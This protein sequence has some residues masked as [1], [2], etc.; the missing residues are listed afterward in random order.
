V[1]FILMSLTC[2]FVLV[3]LGLVSSTGSDN[4]IA[5]ENAQLG[6]RKWQIPANKEAST[7]I[8]A[9]ASATSVMLGDKLTF[10]VSTEIQGDRF[11]V[12]IYR[13]GWYGGDGG[14]LMTSQA[15]LIGQARGYYNSATH[16]LVNCQSCRL[17]NNTGLVEANWLP[18]YSLTIPSDWTT[19]VY[20]AKFSLLSGKETY[21]PFDVRGNAHAA[22]VAVTS[23][24]T[25]QAYNHWGAYSLYE[26][27]GV[28]PTGENSLAP[29]GVMVSFNRPY[30]NGYG[31]GQ[32][33]IF[34]LDAIRWLERQGYDLSYI[35]SVDLH[36]NPGQL[37]QHHAYI[38]LGHDEYW[39]KEMR[40]G[41]EK[42]RDQGVGL[43]FM[44]ADAAYWQIRYQ[45]DGAGIADRII[46]C[47]KVETSNN[48]LARDPLY[49]RDNSRVTSQWRDPA[50]GRPE[51]ALIGVMFSGLTH[52]RLGYA[53]QMDSEV[54]ASQLL[55]GTGLSPG[56][57]YGCN[58]VGY[59]WD[60]V[61]A[62]NAAPKNLQ[63]L[64]TSHT[65]NDQNKPD[66][67]NTTYYIAP[68][69]AMVF[70]TGSIYWMLALDDYRFRA[71]PAC[72]HQNQEVPEM[73]RLMV[74]V[75]AAIVVLHPTG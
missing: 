38:S 4:V 20:L 32:V 36:E 45:P 62:N 51:N 10:Y 60:R 27:E 48:D 21:T 69:G 7:Q 1:F 72:A 37:L 47:Y 63:I 67:S 6:T 58:L 42:A 23:D 18:S 2:A 41:V 53:W 25:Y 12:D 74:N 54:A 26:A 71:D 39:S 59:E 11:S 13:L 44:G 70:A 3:G 14:R 24:N 19:G 15:G 33:L 56:Q 66:V 35:S 5:R 31:D 73:Q 8:Q 61:F 29:K 64:S 75:M 30:A 55:T 65:F 57:E 52:Q 17:D 68:S 9:Y 22:Y 28:A 46:V 50:V 49:G 16:A 43:V 34:E 40:E